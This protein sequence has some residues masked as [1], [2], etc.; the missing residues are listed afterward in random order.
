MK[1]SREKIQ[2]MITVTNSS[3]SASEG[4][5]GGS[6]NLSLGELEDVEIADPEEGDAL[7]YNEE[8]E[9]WGNGQVP[10]KKV[11]DVMYTNEF[12]FLDQSTSDNHV[13]FNFRGR[14][15]GN[16]SSKITEYRFS[17]GQRGNAGVTV[18]AENFFADS[19]LSIVSDARKKIVTDGQMILDLDKIADAPSVKF[20]WKDNDTGEEHIGTI[21]QYWEKVL[22]E[23][24]CKDENGMLSMQ[25]G[26]A[27]LVAAISLAREL[28]EL[29]SKLR[30]YG[31]R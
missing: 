21:A 1:L 4:G 14:Q 22:P 12:N 30:E 10:W 6:T 25:Y 26:T 18:R 19:A 7:V 29:K 23:V 31:I 5:G 28:R 11:K 24:V 2:R 8:D 9:I 17:N 20:R 3:Q 15:G 27:A 16:L 13:H